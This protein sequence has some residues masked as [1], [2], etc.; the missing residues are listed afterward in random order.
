MS[1][2]GR[3]NVVQ[4]SSFLT[5]V[6]ETSHKLIVSFKSTPFK[7][8]KFKSYV[9]CSMKNGH[10]LMKINACA[11]PPNFGGFSLNYSSLCAMH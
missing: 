7:K 10:K 11:N 6:K 2:Q 8:M 1:F 3:F 4:G 5:L 9:G